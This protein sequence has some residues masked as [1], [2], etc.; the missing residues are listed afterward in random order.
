[1]NELR[2]IIEAYEGTKLSGARAVLATVVRTSGSVYRRAGARMLIA[3]GDNVCTVTGAIS[4]GCLERDVCESARG[5]LRKDAPTLVRYDTTA[6]EDIVWGLGLGCNG[7]VEVLLEPLTTKS[8]RR[9]DGEP[10]S[11]SP[12]VVIHPLK[13][14][15]RCYD[16]RGR[17][18][19][20]TVFK[21][22]GAREVRTGARLLA[23]A[24]GILACDIA[25]HELRQRVA[26]D[27]RT[28]LISNRS[29]NNE[30]ESGEGRV[31]VF[32]EV[33]E[34]PVSLVVFGAGSDA[35]PVARLAHELGWFV[36]IV[37]HRAAYVTSTRFPET[38]ELIVCRPEHVAERVRLDARTVTLVMTHNYEHD[39]SII[40]T[41]L[42]SPARY[43]GCLGPKRRT[44]KLL[45]ELRDQEED[46]APTSEQLARLYAPIGLDIGAETPAEIALSILAEI[47]AVVAGRAAGFLRERGGA[48]HG[49]SQIVHEVSAT[50]QEARADA[51]A[52]LI[53]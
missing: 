25:D 3:I 43:V 17:G 8:E 2:A 32:I 15:E 7:V 30:Y 19:M 14:I 18:V 53:A 13:F 4:G 1:M 40:K 42:A 6:A 9:G 36:T 35:V 10:D 37:D 51:A 16:R 26:N 31:D 44:E 45:T 41:L 39:R 49:E 21:V 52:N 22:E 46:F 34:P 48:I 50:Y 28:S 29:S 23:D 11:P 20:A 5:V 38:H 47:R 27:A 24:D 12:G 33:I